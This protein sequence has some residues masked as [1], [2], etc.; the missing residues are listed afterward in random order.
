[1]FDLL[2]H[3]GDIALA[4]TVVAIFVA[5]VRGLGREGPSFADVIAFALKPSFDL[6]WPRG[7]QEEEP[8]RWNVDRFDASKSRVPAPAN[9]GDECPARPVSLGRDGRR[10]LRPSL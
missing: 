1:M 8:V 10:I 5:I 4:A 3:A 9:D 7:V 2:A 6:A